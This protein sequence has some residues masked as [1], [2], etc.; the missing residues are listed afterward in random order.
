MNFSAIFVSRLSDG[1][2]ESFFVGLLGVG[3]EIIEIN[4]IPL[5]DLP[6]E[7]V[8]DLMK[9]SNVLVLKTLPYV[10]RKDK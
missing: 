2:P 3:D 5:K 10:A 6:L 8:Y 1:L 4:G 7:D 9:Q